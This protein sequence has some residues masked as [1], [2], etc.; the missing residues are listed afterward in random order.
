[1]VAHFLFSPYPS[2]RLAWPRVCGGTDHRRRKAM[3]RTQSH[4]WPILIAMES[5]VQSGKLRP[6]RTGRLPPDGLLL[7]SGRRR[8]ECPMNWPG[9]RDRAAGGK[10]DT[11]GTKT[12][13]T[14]NYTQTYDELRPQTSRRQP[15]VAGQRVRGRPIRPSLCGQNCW[16]TFQPAIVEHVSSAPLVRPARCRLVQAS[17]V[18]VR[19]GRQILLSALISRC[20]VGHKSAPSET[21]QFLAAATRFARSA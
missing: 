6:V 19:A 16:C 12:R 3:R 21:C 15:I 18:R 8:L 17:S 7:G 14:M 5:Q 2:A 1:M 20:V 4:R 13:T 9:E 10:R 11:G